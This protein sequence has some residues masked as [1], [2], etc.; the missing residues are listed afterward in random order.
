MP[1][2]HQPHPSILPSP[3]RGLSNEAADP[4]LPTWLTLKAL[5]SGAWNFS[6]SDERLLPQSECIQACS[7][8]VKRS[9]RFGRRQAV[10]ALDV[11]KT[12]S[13]WQKKK[14]SAQD[15]M[16]ELKHWILMAPYVGREHRQQ[17]EH[18]S[19]SGSLRWVSAARIRSESLSL[20]KRYSFY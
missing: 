16:A 4:Y 2:P 6:G 19:H 15:K 17:A 8:F 3:S 7:H 13:D 11:V 1:S 14:C 20:H 18:A 5:N 10:I 12:H 9:I